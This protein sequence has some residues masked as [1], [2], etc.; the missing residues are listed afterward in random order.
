MFHQDPP[1]QEPQLAAAAGSEDAEADAA[2]ELM[3]AHDNEAGRMQPEQDAQGQH[4]NHYQDND[5]EYAFTDFARLL[6]NICLQRPILLGLAWSRAGAN[7]H[8]FCPRA[9]A[10][11]KSSR[12]L[13]TSNPQPC[14]NTVLTGSCCVQLWRK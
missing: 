2:A 8:A 7:L 14:L 4:R 10:S 3:P 1:A 12:V 9:I 6:S 13:G 11:Q 5:D